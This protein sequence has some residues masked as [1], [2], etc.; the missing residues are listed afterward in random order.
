[1]E[2][3]AEWILEATEQGIWR[4]RWFDFVGSDFVLE[5]GLFFCSPLIWPF[6]CVP[7]GDTSDPATLGRWMFPHPITI[8]SRPYLSFNYN[9]SIP[10]LFFLFI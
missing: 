2:D 6:C 5:F 8:F 10:L 7:R 3:G 9:F 4:S 1:M